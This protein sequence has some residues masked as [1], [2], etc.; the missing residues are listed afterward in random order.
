MPQPTLYT[1]VQ[2]G[3]LSCRNIGG[4]SKRA[5]LVRADAET[6]AALKAI[7]ATPPHWRRPPPGLANS[8]ATPATEILKVAMPGRY[9][10]ASDICKAAR[11]SKPEARSCW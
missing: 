3:R 1:W 7:R 9:R 5:K 4:G 6:I 8:A 11:L 10:P 2:K